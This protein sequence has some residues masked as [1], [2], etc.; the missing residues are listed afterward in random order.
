MIRILVA[1]VLA[2][3]VALP[4]S[5]RDLAFLI[6]NADYSRLEPVP[7]ARQMAGLAGQFRQAGY[8]VEILDNLDAARN[9]AF[10]DLL[11]TRARDADRLVVVLCGQIV[12]HGFDGWLLGTDAKAEAVADLDSEGLSI[13]TLAEI[14]KSHPDKA[15]ILV[16][17]TN[18]AAPVLPGA[19]TDLGGMWMPKG[20][21]LLQTPTDRL[22]TLVQGGLLQPGQS[23][24]DL[25]VASD[26]V[27]RPAGY[28]T[29]A[30]LVDDPA[31][32]AWMAAMA[33]GGLVDYQSFLT[34]FPDSAQAA[35]AQQRIATLH[36]QRRQRAEGVE[37]RVAASETA[38]KYIQRDLDRLGYDTRGIDGIFGQ[39]T[40]GAIAAW[41]TSRGLGGVRGYLTADQVALLHTQA[42]RFAERTPAPAR[43]VRVS[44]PE[45]SSLS[46][47]TTRRRVEE[48][49]AQM[50]YGTGAVDGR[51]DM[52]TRNAVRRYQRDRGLDVTG[53]VTPHTLAVLMAGRL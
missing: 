12:S 43:T 16:A 2:A 46:S 7:E 24:R 11:R 25:V 48:R 42:R 17:A 47:L 6:G 15:L 29:D 39:G 35:Q 13:R 41:Q 4:V 10:T 36:E 52:A 50:G 1:S 34:R 22:M 9:A 21:T 23:L 14:S 3:M 8:E 51:F 5:A 40:R 28:V 27:L 44:A 32:K 26:G 53:F 45:A 19:G 30:P 31:E 38:R 37:R 49:L 20:V 33:R 18:A